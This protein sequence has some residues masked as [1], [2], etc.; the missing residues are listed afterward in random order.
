MPTGLKVNDKQS[1]VNLTWDKAS[2]RGTNGGA[3]ITDDVTF[4]V[5]RARSNGGVTNLQLLHS[6]KDNTYSDNISTTEG[7]QQLRLYAVSAKNDKGES[8]PLLSP[9]VITGAAYQLPF[10][11]GFT[12][13]AGAP[14]W[15]SLTADEDNGIGFLQNTQTSSDG[16]NNCLTFTSYKN[17]LLYTSP[18]PR[19]AHEPRMPSSA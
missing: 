17:C 9:A 15:W 4:N 12:T 2:A 19:D 6:P 1:S 8:T 10:R 11:S 7:A 5:Y 16:D 14:L 18:S 13:E 3:V